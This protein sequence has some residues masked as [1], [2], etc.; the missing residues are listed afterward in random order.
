M[1]KLVVGT[2]ALLVLLSGI[3]SVP[4]ADAQTGTPHG[5]FLEW[6]ASTS[7]VQGYT[8]FR[9]LGT[10]LV[11]DPAANWIAQNSAVIPGLKFYDPALGLTPGTTYSYAVVAV[12]AAG[13]QSAFSNIATALWPSPPPTNP[14]PPSGCKATAK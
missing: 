10:C 5:I 13:S 3:P 2:I 4:Q 1:R 11:T 12:D 14:G 9:C 6:A 7:V 8:V